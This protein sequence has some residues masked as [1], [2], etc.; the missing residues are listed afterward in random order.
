VAEVL[1]DLARDL[2]KAARRALG[3]VGVQLRAVDRDDPDRTSPDSAQSPSTS[4][5]SPAN[6]AS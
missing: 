4:P 2:L 6:A 1:E 3:R 5:N